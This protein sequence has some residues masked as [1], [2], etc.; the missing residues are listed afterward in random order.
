VTGENCNGRNF[1]IVPK[2]KKVSFALE[3][4]MKGQWW[5]RVAALLFL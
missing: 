3:Q 4:A 5:S 1:M 2:V